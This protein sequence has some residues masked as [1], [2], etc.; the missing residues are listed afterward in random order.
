VIITP[1]PLYHI[2]SLTANCLTFMTLGGENILI[3]NPRDIPGFIA[4]M[5]KYSSRRSP[6]STRSSMRRQSEFAKLDFTSLK[7]TSAAD[8]G[9]GGGR[10]QVEGD[11]RLHVD[12]SVGLDRDFSGGHHQPARPARVQRP[13]GPADLVDRDRAARR[14]GQ[15]RALGPTREI[16]I[17]GRR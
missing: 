3:R 12:R 11:H 15:G 4:E 17:R 7:M 14:R 13:I 1:L 9:A 6:A 16:C 8:G 5:G 2:F 10:P